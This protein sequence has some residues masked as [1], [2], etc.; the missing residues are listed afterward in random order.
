VPEY[1]VVTI[2]VAASGKLELPKITSQDQL[3][4][5]LNRLASIREDQVLPS[6]I[7]WQIFKAISC[8]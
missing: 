8:N 5:A 1:I 7:F 4:K 3:V 2:L 6:P